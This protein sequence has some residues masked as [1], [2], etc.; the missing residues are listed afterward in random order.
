V[1]VSRKPDGVASRSTQR[2]VYALLTAVICFAAAGIAIQHFNAEIGASISRAARF[3]TT[4]NASNGKIDVAR[5]KVAFALWRV[6]PS[7]ARRRDLSTAFAVVAGWTADLQR[8]AFG[9]LAR[10]DATMAAEAAAVMAT[11]WMLQPLLAAPDAPGAVER[12]DA[13][14]A[15]L[16]EPVAGLVSGAMAHSI[17]R[18]RADAEL[19]RQQQEEQLALEIGLLV[20]VSGLIGLLTTPSATPRATSF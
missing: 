6:D 1:S 19:M 7:A 5:L 4:L 2:V 8:G 14:L 18:S 20:S 13:L 17:D 9:E 15:T 16:D 11:V 12:A 3:E 10:S